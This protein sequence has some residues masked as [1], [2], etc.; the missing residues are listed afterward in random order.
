MTVWHGLLNCHQ[1]FTSS[2][3]FKIWIFSQFLR[4]TL[5]LEKV[6]AHRWLFSEQADLSLKNSESNDPPILWASADNCG[7]WKFN[8]RKVLAR[9]CCFW[10]AGWFEPEWHAWCLP[11]HIGWV[12]QLISLQNEGFESAIAKCDVGSEMTIRED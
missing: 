12:F 11:S 1:G 2:H 8:R 3:S 5:S 9:S 7:R 4:P 10:S 6:L